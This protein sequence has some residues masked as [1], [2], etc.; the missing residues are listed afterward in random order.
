MS[1][2]LVHRSPVAA[3]AEGGR[4]CRAAPG[5]RVAPRALISAARKNAA[6]LELDRCAAVLLTRGIAQIN[7]QRLVL[8]RD[9]GGIPADRRESLASLR[10]FRSSRAASKGS[11]RDTRARRLRVN[12]TVRRCRTPR[13]VDGSG[14]LPETRRPQASGRGLD[15]NPHS[16]A[17][18]RTI[19]DGR[20]VPVGNGLRREAVE[21]GRLP[22]AL[23][24]RLPSRGG[25]SQVLTTS[26]AAVQRPNSTRRCW[27]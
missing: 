20:M 9:R 8:L 10:F 2:F 1:G 23:H 27:V 13:N 25:R 24:A 3:K 18:Q 15:N 5:R 17:E 19:T 4:D 22:S 11:L 16:I 21:E 12:T 7:W 6:P 26:E 14:Y